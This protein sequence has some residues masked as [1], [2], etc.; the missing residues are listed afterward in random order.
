MRD[1][2]AA[3]IDAFLRRHTSACRLFE[4]LD[5]KARRVTLPS[6]RHCI[7][8][9]TVGFISDLPHQLINAFRATL[10]EVLQADV[11]L[12][13]LDAANPAVQDQHRTVI[14]V[15]K[16]LGLSSQMLQDRV[17]EVWNKVDLL[18]QTQASH[19]LVMKLQSE[20]ARASENP[21]TASSEGSEDDNGAELLPVAMRPIPVNAVPV[22]VLEGVGMQ[23]L[24]RTLD[25]KLAA[26]QP[27]P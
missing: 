4:T 5:T 20:Q 16:Q 21:G 3:S 25:N 6:G 23:D 13:V 10:E 22:S 11:L 7:M 18:H 17:V 27:S 24:L 14:G 2:L 9:D 8:S 12:H 26:K 15:L 19:G 1:H